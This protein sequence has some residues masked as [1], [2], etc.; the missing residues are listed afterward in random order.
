MDK[1][2]WCT[3]QIYTKKAQ[4]NTAAE[5][6]SDHNPVYLQINEW[7][8]NLTAQNYKKIYWKNYVT[9]L[10]LTEQY[11]QLETLHN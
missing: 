7:Q 4:T 6:I 5:R 8:G 3:W 11:Q 2:S 9:T 10:K 1:R